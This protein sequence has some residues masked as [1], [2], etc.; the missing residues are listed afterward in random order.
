MSGTT[1]SEMDIS[2]HAPTRGATKTQLNCRGFRRISIHAPTRGATVRT[3][4]RSN[5]KRFQSTLPQGERLRNRES[6]RE[7]R[8]FQST[9]PQGERRITGRIYRRDCNFNPRS[10]KGS[11][12]AN[13]LPE[14]NYRISIHAPTRGATK[15]STT[16]QKRQKLFQS[17]LPQGERQIVAAS[18]LLP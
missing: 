13:G 1:A 11:D 4:I 7:K 15:E 18:M 10:H 3:A 6:G 17:T 5:S 9:L 8:L 12:N 2:I 14:Q 16:T